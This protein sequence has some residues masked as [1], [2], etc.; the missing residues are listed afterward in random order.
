MRQHGVRRGAD[1]HKVAVDAAGASV[2]RNIDCGRQLAVQVGPGGARGREPGATQAGGLASFAL[3]VA[4][5]CSA[6]ASTLA[7]AVKAAFIPLTQ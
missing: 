3:A 4:R 5:P 6:A 7:R 2:C 1:R